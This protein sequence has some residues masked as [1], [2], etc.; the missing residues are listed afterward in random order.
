[1]TQEEAIAQAVPWVLALVGGG[2]GVVALVKGI[3]AYIRK[4]QD[5]ESRLAELERV[6][7]AL[8][9]KVDEFH[10]IVAGEHGL[11]SKLARYD[12]QIQ[13]WA[14]W[15][16]D[17]MDKELSRIAGEVGAHDDDIED[18]RKELSLC[19]RRDTTRPRG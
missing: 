9:R 11:Y 10:E 6:S 12:E 17:V 8:R 16:H 5:R 19:E 14:R 2:G 13:N 1:M 7:A 3:F 18:I 4:E 15:R